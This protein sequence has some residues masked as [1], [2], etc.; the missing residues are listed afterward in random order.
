[1]QRTRMIIGAAAVLAAATAC[2]TTKAAGPTGTT[3]ASAP[4]SAPV[5]V[6]STA[7]APT[8]T[9]TAV[10]PSAAVAGG[11]CHT[12]QLT[13]SLGG[14]GSGLSNVG[15][16]IVLTNTG[17]VTCT[18]TGYPGIGLL[19][20]AK[21]LDS[22]TVPRGGTY[23]YQDPR[24]HTVSLSP[25]ASASAGLGYLNGG[26]SA[27]PANVACEDVAYLSITPPDETAALVLP[28]DPNKDGTICGVQ[29]ITALTAG[30]DVGQPQG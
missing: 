11:R 12:P 10:N 8:V 7:A 30:R 27:Y 4:T 5:T 18:V 1:M 17:S 26:R 2:G 21:H 9:T 28:F 13:A 14:G 15:Q 23:I 6:T 3:P 16:A 19:D 22:T 25:G 24:S 29:G 20:A